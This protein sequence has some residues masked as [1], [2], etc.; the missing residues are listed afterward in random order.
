MYQPNS[1]RLFT[2]FSARVFVI[3]LISGQIFGQNSVQQSVNEPKIIEPGKDGGPPSDA[4][5]LFNGKDLSDWQGLNGGPAKWLV[6][7]GVMTVAPFTGNIS[8]KQEF[9]DV[10]LH[11]EW[12][13]PAEV[14]GKDQGRGNSGVFFMGRYEVQILDSYNNKTYYDGQAAAVYKQ[15]APL[16]NA[17]RGPGEWQTYDIIFHSPAF[18]EQ[19]K[20]AKRARVTVLHNG[21]LVQDNVELI[22]STSLKGGYTPDTSVAYSNHPPKAPILLQDHHNSVR[23]RNIWVRPL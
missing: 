3:L 2:S 12:A 23:F 9:G 19:G 5:I 11:I 14:V 7:D 20:V 10:Q 16:V 1:S 8:S 15:Y 17:S 6:K 21:V 13:T 4:I 18:D 22:G